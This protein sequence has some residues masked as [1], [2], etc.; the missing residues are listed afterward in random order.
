[1]LIDELRTYSAIAGI[2]DDLNIAFNEAV[3]ARI[4]ENQERFLQEHENE[5]I[6]DM[7]IFETL[8]KTIPANLQ[9]DNKSWKRIF[10]SHGFT[11]NSSEAGQH[12]HAVTNRIKEIQE[13]IPSEE[14]LAIIDRLKALHFNI[15]SMP[16][17]QP[18]RSPEKPANVEHYTWKKT[19]SIRIDDAE[20]NA[21]AKQPLADTSDETFMRVL[22]RLRELAK[23]DIISNRECPTKF[24]SI[25]EDIVKRKCGTSY[26]WTDGHA[27]RIRAEEIYQIMGCTHFMS[28]FATSQFCQIDQ[29]GSH[30]EVPYTYETL[31]RA[32]QCSVPI[33]LSTG[34]ST[35][36]ACW[37][38]SK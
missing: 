22:P 8:K 15:N 18:Q 23:E 3:L 33:Y 11:E 30:L 27:N 26:T 36:R 12:R 35:Y 6:A 29:N 31:A 10:K 19:A 4:S 34:G 9:V 21:L 17:I 2:V 28:G 7:K 16:A 37:Y 13:E 5:L 20:V 1:M 14:E 32:T 38:T 24:L 25:V